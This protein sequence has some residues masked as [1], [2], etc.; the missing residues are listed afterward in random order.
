MA[1]A[2]NGDLGAL[3]KL[4]APGPRI[5]PRMFH[6]IRLS[7]CLSVCLCASTNQKVVMDTSY[8]VDH[9]ISGCEYLFR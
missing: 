9:R 8:I 1:S 4:L 7:V 5:A 6:L 3:P 2:Y